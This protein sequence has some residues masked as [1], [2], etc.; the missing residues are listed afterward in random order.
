MNFEE[1]RAWVQFVRRIRQELQWSLRE[2]AAAM[3]TS[4]STVCRW[5]DESL[6]G[7]TPTGAAKKALIELARKHGLVE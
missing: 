4:Q 6:R 2:M 1:R 5:E 3:G 7:R